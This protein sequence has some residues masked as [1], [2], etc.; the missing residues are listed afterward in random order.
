MPLDAL[1]SIL[2]CSLIVSMKFWLV[3]RFQRQLAGVLFQLNEFGDQKRRMVTNWWIFRVKLGRTCHET[4][5]I[6]LKRN[7][8]PRRDVEGFGMPEVHFV[9]ETSPT[10]SPSYLSSVFF[11]GKAFV[12]TAFYNEFAA[13]TAEA[14]KRLCID[15]MKILLSAS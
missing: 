3:I 13:F 12:S 11:M 7:E 8:H 2:G 4:D 14:Q 9:L 1:E 6:A 15:L 10:D 5:E